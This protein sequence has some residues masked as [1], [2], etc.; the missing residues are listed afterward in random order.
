MKKKD[1][2]TA[3]SV[4]ASLC[5][6][7]DFLSQYSQDMVVAKSVTD[8][9]EVL[10]GETYMKSTETSYGMNN[11]TCGFFNMLDDDI[12][13]VGVKSTEKLG[14][15]DAY[16]YVVNGM[17]GYYAWQ[18]DV[19]YNYEH[20]SYNSDDGTWNDLYHRINVANIL[21][22]E[23]EDVPHK[24]DTDLSD[25]T[26]VKGEIL[27]LRAQFYF[28]LANLYGKA[29]NPATCSTDLCVPLK[30]THYV[31]YDKN[32]DTQFERAT[33]ADIYAQVVSDL[34]QAESL[35]K[36]SP[37]KTG[38][39]LHRASWQA[40]DLLL[41]RVYL[42]M[43]DWASAEQK[44]GE[45]V[46]DTQFSLLSIANFSD[47]TPVLTA[48]NREIIFSQGGNKLTPNRS[49]SLAA[50]VY[51][52]PSEYCV[53]RQLYDLYDDNDARKSSYFGR[54][55][56]SDSIRL[57]KYEREVKLNDISDALALRK[58]EAYLNYAEACAM[59]D[60][61]ERQANEALNTLRRQ[62]IESW[63][64]TDYTG[65][66]LAEQIMLERRRELCFEGQR[67][68]DLR[69]YAVRDKY[70]SAT[71]ILHVFNEYTDNGV[72]VRAH[73][74]LLKSTDKSWTFGIPR[75]VLEADKVPMTDNERDQRDELE[76][77]EKQ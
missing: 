53:T 31:E 61:K 49:S 1:I 76:N 4:I 34:L 26:R 60:G 15:Y 19:R 46:S 37:Q 55:S 9:E 72:C 17:F 5:S 40:V 30:L 58:S 50:S 14:S 28:I 20:D 51:G 54:N 65:R 71:D 64:D 23:L 18:Q 57:N 3:L 13:T 38:S 11:G 56:Q 52:N 36:E 47:G 75:A 59:Q 21:L 35:L 12:N 29:Y 43:Q 25:Y 69:R 66:Q 6:C 45:V 24:T 70:P 74:Y 73:Y 39:T 10:I 68:F 27:F 8:I 67:W 2:L 33:V 63:Y 32:K 42:Y 7:G 44:A 62:R 77:T 41:S 16:T 48:N 22:H